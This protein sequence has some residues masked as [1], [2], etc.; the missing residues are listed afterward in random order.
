MVRTQRIAS[1]GVAVNAPAAAAA[2]PAKQKARP[3][4]AG[5]RRRNYAARGDAQRS[6]HQNSGCA[7]RHS[8]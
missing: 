7:L 8:A 1:R 3:E 5:P 6:H 4:L 2:R